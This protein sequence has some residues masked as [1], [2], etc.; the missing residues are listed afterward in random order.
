MRLNDLKRFLDPVK[1]HHPADGPVAGIAHHSGA[2]KPGFV[3]VAERGEKHN[4][5]R[6]AAEAVSRGAAAVVAEELP[7]LPHAVPVFVVRD[8]RRAL[9][10]LA[11]EWHGHPS[12]SL[13]VHGVT[14]TNGKTTTAFLLASILRAAG[15]KT[16]ILGTIRYEIGPRVI[17]APNTTPGALELQSYLAEMVQAGMTAVVMEVSSHAIALSRI[18]GLNFRSGIFTNLSPEHLDYHGTLEN[19]RDTKAA[20]FRALPSDAV[21]AI[22]AEDAAGEFMAAAAGGRILRF[23][24][25]SGDVR[26]RVIANGLDGLEVAIAFP[27]PAGTV[28]VKSRLV[29]RYNAYNIIAAATAAWGAGLPADIVAAGLSRAEPVPGRLEPVPNGRGIFVFVD[30]A[31][32]DAALRNVLEVVRG[33]VKGRLVV[34]FGCGGDRDRTKRPR[35]GQVASELADHVVVTTDN[36]RSEDPDAIMREIMAGMAGTHHEGVRDREAAIAR[37]IA[38]ARPGDV[39]VICGKG[40]ETYQILRE[41]VVPFDDREVARRALG[42]SPVA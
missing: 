9:A 30:Y 19:Y 39:V 16:G 22:N 6:Y 7:A 17:P 15:R 3:F 36:P 13:E 5:H 18:E 41:T 26:G 42:A 35:M 33:L 21:A 10:C 37:G 38:A 24:L 40:H 1:V 20:F 8:S 32:T 4:G 2:V 11:A 23:G 31:H 34:V 28:T 27:A 12:R 14:G 25:A 29:G